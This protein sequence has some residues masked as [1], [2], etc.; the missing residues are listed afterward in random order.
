MKK[1]QLFRRGLL[2]VLF[3]GF[4]PLQLTVYAEET[5][6]ENVDPVVTKIYIVRHAERDP[7]LDPSLNALGKKRAS[8][9]K[10]VLID[11]GITAVYYPNWK[12]NHQTA[13]PLLE[14]TGIRP[15]RLDRVLLNDTEQFAKNLAEQI[16]RESLGETI[17]YIGNQKGVGKQMGNIQELYY[18]LGGEGTPLTRYF[19]MYIL[20]LHD[21]EI[22][23][24][25]HTRY[26]EI[27]KDLFTM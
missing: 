14:A 7:G 2:A 8:A 11:S 10:E 18:A 26:G 21:K 20:T 3:M 22:V 13:E 27:T 6:N 15:V 17:L 12:R 23:K 16:Y 19:D 25:Q 5:A 24:V 9:L 4:I 1:S